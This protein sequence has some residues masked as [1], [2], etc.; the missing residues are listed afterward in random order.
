MVHP[1]G[2]ASDMKLPPWDA[3]QQMVLMVN[4]VQTEAADKPPAYPGAHGKFDI[5]ILSAPSGTLG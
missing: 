4:G 1:M 5:P 2:T 3:A